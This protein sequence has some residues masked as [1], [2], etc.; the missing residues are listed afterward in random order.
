[1]A[2]NGTDAPNTEAAAQTGDKPQVRQR[3]LAQYIRDLSFENVMAQKSLQGEI[4]PEVTVQVKLDAH[5]RGGD[6]QYEVVMKLSVTSKSKGT[7]ETLFLLEIEYAG[8]FMIEGLPEEQ[9]H[10][11]LLIECPRLLFPFLR[12]IISDI[13]RDGG[14]PP[15]NLETIDFLALYRQEIARRVADQK[16]QKTADA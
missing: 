2:E 12:R 5:R 7:E 3:I 1:M 14:F 4:Q 11:Y 6:N 8:V 13:T 10:P 16:K 9:L 15:F